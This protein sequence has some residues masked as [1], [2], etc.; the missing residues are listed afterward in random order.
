MEENNY[1]YYDVKNPFEPKKRRPT[2][3]TVLCILTFIGSGFSIL[4]N[5]MWIFMGKYMASMQMSGPFQTEQMQETIR[6]MGETASWKYL[7][8]VLLYLTSLMGAIFMLYLKKLGFHLYTAAQV[9]LLF[10][11]SLLIFKQFKPDLYSLFFTVLFIVFYGIHYKFMT[12]NLNDE[13]ETLNETDTNED[14]Q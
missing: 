6:I 14:E 1:Q 11:P 7:I 2:F 3:L 9:L 12:W 4:S 8:L 13:K 5:A 10:L